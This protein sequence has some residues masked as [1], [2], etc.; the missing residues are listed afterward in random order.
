MGNN[1]CCLD[2]TLRDLT[3]LSPHKEVGNFL[4]VLSL[5]SVCVGHVGI[6]NGCG[7]F[8][9]CCGL[10]IISVRFCIL[11]CSKW[12]VKFVCSFSVVR[13]FRGFVVEQLQKGKYVVFTFNFLRK[14][15]DAQ[16]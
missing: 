13:Y 14:K 7:L 9:F 5:H 10:W 6:Q 1:C 8:Q 12:L 3:S 11:E 16:F 2:F 15:C 4:S